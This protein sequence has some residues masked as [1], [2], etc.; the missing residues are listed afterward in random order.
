MKRCLMYMQQLLAFM[1]LRLPQRFARANA[2]SVHPFPLAL[3]PA[4]IGAALS[5]G[6]WL[7]GCLAAPA[8]AQ[9]RVRWVPKAERG[10][11]A[12]TVSGGRRGDSAC[13]KQGQHLALLVPASSQKAL[14]ATA[15]P[16]FYWQVQTKAPLETTFTL[17][18]SGK[19]VPHYRL[20]QIQSSAGVA[21]VKLPATHPLQPGKRYRW[22]VSATCQDAAIMIARSSV[23]YI[24][25]APLLAEQNGRQFAQAASF[26]SQ[27]F[28]YDAVEQLMQVPPSDARHPQAQEDLR[29][30]LQQATLGTTRAH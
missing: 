9:P 18:E 8:T 27:G 23:E 22:M 7:L 29:S 4:G 13:P 24:A 10:S 25:A 6:C 5:L 2:P 14:S 20:T 3:A 12:S 19:T 15:T 30:L 1:A 26:A 21:Q 16:T 28:W 17:I 11:V